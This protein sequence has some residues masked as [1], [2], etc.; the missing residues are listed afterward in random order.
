MA[1]PLTIAGLLIGLG[2]L[3]VKC[4]ELF[5]GK[6]TRKKQEAARRFNIA[7]TA[8]EDYLDSHDLR[9]NR[10]LEEE[11]RLQRLWE[12]ASRAIYPLSKEVAYTLSRKSDY[13]RNPTRWT[14]SQIK[15]ARIRLRDVCMEASKY[16]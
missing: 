7:L 13:W 6:P 12:E 9:K 2:N 14:K 10:D 1:D 15:Q 8:T 16:V 11:R 3:A 5:S 4:I